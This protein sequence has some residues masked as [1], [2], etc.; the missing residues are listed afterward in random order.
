[1]DNKKEEEGFFY[2]SLHK[3]NLEIEEVSS[4]LSPED[5]T[6]HYSLNIGNSVGGLEYVNWEVKE[7]EKQI[8]ILKNNKGIPFVLK[9]NVFPALVDIK[10]Y[11]TNPVSQ[12]WINKSF[13]E[14]SISK[15]V[16]AFPEGIKTY[17][18]CISYIKNKDLIVTEFLMENAGIPLT[19]SMDYFYGRTDRILKA[20]TQSSR[21]L[22]Y[23]EKLKISYND[24]KLENFL[25]DAKQNLR[26]ID[27]D[28]SQTQGMTTLFVNQVDKVLGLTR[29]YAS[30]EIINFYDRQKNHK[31]PT[32]EKVDPYRADVYS[33]GIMALVL[34]GKLQNNRIMEIDKYKINKEENDQKFAGI[35]DTISFEEQPNL[36]ENVRLLLKTC[37]KFNPK[38]RLKFNIIRKL[39]PE[40][41]CLSKDIFKTIIDDNLLHVNNSHKSSPLKQN[42]ILNDQRQ[43]YKQRIENQN[44][45]LIKNE[46]NIGTINIFNFSDENLKGSCLSNDNVS[47][48][49]SLNPYNFVLHNSSQAT[50]NVYLNSKVL[51][52]T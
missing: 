3:E 4:S 16:S 37:L 49:V 26:I 42:E 33:W 7:K 20:L 27:Y 23:L 14:Y 21:I 13:N 29:G 50:P 44:K 35:V 28:I 17:D 51:T 36:T 24:L 18:F 48:N 46:L 11:L 39:V 22:S 19:K 45:L 34:F 5:N 8:L 41:H 1:M 47:T 25:L 52:R 43:I 38:E 10:T 2:F 30:P 32:G 31:Q 6:T 12:V 15:L 9:R 40:I